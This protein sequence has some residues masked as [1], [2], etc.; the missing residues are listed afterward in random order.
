MG[1]DLP[2][3]I[4]SFYGSRGGCPIILV[5]GDGSIQM[6]IQEMQ[7]IVHN[8]LPIKMFVLNNNGYISIR[9]T[10][11]AFFKGHFVGSSPE[12][13]V[14]CP[15]IVEI[16]K[17]YG[18]VGRRIKN[19][20]KLKQQVKSILDYKG[21]IVCEIMLNPDEEMEPKL[22]SEL[23]PGGKIV[24]KPLEDMY[25]FL[26]RNVFKSNMIIPTINE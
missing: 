23:K 3:A 16:A 22:S 21:S 11:R 9:N 5:T 7:T 10:Q 14:S 8:K 25:P 13:G 17:A 18:L 26:D 1:Y 4:G 15:D 2:A 20:Q 12:S 19:Q 24:S 6:N